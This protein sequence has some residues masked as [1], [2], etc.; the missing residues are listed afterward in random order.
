[1][2]IFVVYDKN[3]SQEKAGEREKHNSDNVNQRQHVFINLNSKSVTKRKKSVKL[4]INTSGTFVFLEWLLL[5][6][7][8]L[9]FFNDFI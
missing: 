3:D 4:S 7:L 8:L 9:H 2:T 6:S 5:L 1:M